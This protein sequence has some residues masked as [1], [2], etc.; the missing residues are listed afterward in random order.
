MGEKL[1]HRQCRFDTE[2]QSNM[3]GIKRSSASKAGHSSSRL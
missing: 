1:V 3:M 2:G